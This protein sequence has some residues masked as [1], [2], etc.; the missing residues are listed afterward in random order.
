MA[1]F[2]RDKNGNTSYKYSNGNGW[3]R[4]ADRSTI[5]VRQGNVEKTIVNA[6]VVSVTFHKTN[7]TSQTH[8][9]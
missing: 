1:G 4:S 7:G 6:K 8:K 2:G 5:T 3:K 9:K